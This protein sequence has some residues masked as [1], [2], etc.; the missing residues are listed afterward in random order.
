MDYQTVK[1]AG[2]KWG[3][4]SRM[5]NI[6]IPQEELWEQKRRVTYGLYP[7]IKKNQ[8]TEE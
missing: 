7:H 8:T 2:V 6:I 4:T 5:V 1:E 3:I